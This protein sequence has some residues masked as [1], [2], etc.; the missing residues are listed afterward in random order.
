MKPGNIENIIRSLIEKDGP[1]TFEKFMALVLYCP[2]LGYYMTDDIRIGS[3]GDYYTSPHLHPI[4]GWMIAVQLDE[5]KRILTGIDE[6]TILEIGAGRGYFAENIID[7]LE[8]KLQWTGN[9]KYVI[10]EKNP[11]AI[12]HQSK[13]LNRYQGRVSWKT[14]IDEVDRFCGCVIAN[15]LIDAFPVHRIT[16]MGRFREI[17]VDVSANGLVELAGD[18]SDPALC[19]YLAQYKMPEIKGYSSE[20]NLRIRDHLKSLDNVLS[21]GFELTI[22]YGYPAWEYYSAQRKYG[23][24]FCY[25]RHTRNTNPY[26]H[27]G[28]QDIT[29][30][31]NFTA[32][33]D[34]GQA[35]GLQTIGYCPQGTFLASLGIDKVIA[36]E[37]ESN[38]SFQTELLRIKGLLFD[39]G[40][41]HKVM[42]QYKGQKD[43]KSL[44]GFELSNRKNRL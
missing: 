44:N 7:Y 23:T 21:E 8:H 11:S 30:H 12:Q 18:F 25:Y 26:A 29:A 1:I 22:D 27:L 41:T 10:V 16:M 24:L 33:K 4:F 19:S 36:A 6:F 2:G 20:V 5:M 15:E 38:P 3:D 14:A 40:Q 9:W 37:L 17:Y 43:I 39:I 32:L 34:W 28:N 42:I 35:A 13:L 31:V